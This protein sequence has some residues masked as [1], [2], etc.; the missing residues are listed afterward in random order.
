MISFSQTR[1]RKVLSEIE[2]IMTENWKPVGMYIWSIW[3]V[4]Y[5]VEN[6][7]NELVGDL[8]Q[9]HA[10][11]ISNAFITNTNLKLAKNQVNA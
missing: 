2:I 6:N 10:F 5:E 3:T 4:S 1:L 8:F 11:F 7:M 9:L